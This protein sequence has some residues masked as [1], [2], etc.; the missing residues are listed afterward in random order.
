MKLHVRNLLQS[1]RTISL[2]F[3]LH[4][5]K[6][7][8]EKESLLKNNERRKTEG[9]R[10]GGMSGLGKDNDSEPKWGARENEY[11]HKK[12]LEDIEDL[13]QRLEKERKK[14]R[15]RMIHLRSLETKTID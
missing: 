7:G 2:G 1:R 5:P 4:I 13:R 14:E 3:S 10:R 12:N 9:T 8:D 15:K 6:Q 11:F